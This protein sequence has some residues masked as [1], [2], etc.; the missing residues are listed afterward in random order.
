[1]SDAVSVEEDPG[2]HGPG[3]MLKSARA[4]R[5]LSLADIAQRLKYGERQIE[6]LEAEAFGS[7]PGPTIV[8]GMV[9]GYCKLLEI[10]PAPVLQSLERRAMPSAATVDS[11]AI[12]I[13]F[14]DS[15]RRSTRLFL[16]LS[17]LVA[18]AALAVGVEWH[19]GNS[20]SL[21]PAV[22]PT[23]NGTRL[24]D[25][26]RAAEKEATATAP[27]VEPTQAVEPRLEITAAEA[28]SA[29]VAPRVTPFSSRTDAQKRILLD[30]QREAWVEIKEKGG[31]TL[32]S[33]MNPC[34]TQMVLEGVPPFEIV[35]GNAP[36]V[37]LRYKDEPVDL[38]PHFKVD[39]ARLT[40]D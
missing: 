25:N 3:A 9:R 27:A 21:L 18:L 32:V 30:F 13:P 5:G 39:V 36:N 14:P 33:Q 20:F 16:G 24:P 12:E 26:P 6:A 37:R 8:R 10:D 19:F 35:I 17:A 40:L 11:P 2:E 38:R 7:L 23:Q 22:V 31:K 4:R 28:Q 1:M 34:G 15:T 29:A